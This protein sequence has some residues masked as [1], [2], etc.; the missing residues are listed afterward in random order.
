MKVDQGGRRRRTP[1]TQ[2]L[3]REEWAVGIGH[4]KAEKTR[5]DSKG[6]LGRPEQRGTTYRERRREEA[7]HC[8]SAV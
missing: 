8:S 6:R 1:K 3:K 7:R 4:Q 5:W 2:R